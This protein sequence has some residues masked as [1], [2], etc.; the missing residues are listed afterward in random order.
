VFVISILVLIYVGLVYVRPQEYVLA[1]QDIP[2]LPA[3]LM[4]S[5]A[6]W[7]FQPKKNFEASQHWLLPILLFAMALSVAASGWLGGALVTITEFSPIVALFYLISTST[8]SLT[9]HRLFMSTLAILTTVLALHGIDQIET[10]VGWSGA[11][12]IEGR[13]TYLGVFNDPNDLALAFVV[14]LPMIGYGLSEGKRFISK[15]FWS[16]AFLIV[17]Y[18]IYLTNS[19]GGMLGTI[20][21]FLLYFHTRFG[22]LRTLIVG[23]I[24]LMAL[25]LLPTRLDELD[26]GE[27]SAAGRVDAWYEGIQL[28]LSKPVLGV[29]KG[30]FGD[31][32]RLTAHNSFVLAF[33]ELGLVGYF[34]WLAFVGLSIYMVYKIS[35][36]TADQMGEPGDI[37]KTE[38]AEYRKVARTYL[39]TMLGFFSCAFFL[40]RSYNI[41]LFIL[42]A[43]CVALYQLVR[44]RWPRFVAIPFGEIIGRTVVFEIGSIVFMFI[45]VKI[46]L[47]LGQ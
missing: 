35:I 4:A 47:A 15:V 22:T 13:I 26:A 21:L 40:S 31:H 30:L 17:L 16:S 37:E 1:L 38:W 32:N 3:F 42:C 14:A 44:H 29:G 41:L 5:V 23:S 9:K 34:F 46:L 19:R 25:S 28:L 11:Q 36:T 10:G 39:Y 24:G 27:A 20:A 33:A 7:M 45:L 12:V 8:D 43:L 2:V 6:V 18:G